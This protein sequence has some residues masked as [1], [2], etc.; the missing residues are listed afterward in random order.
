MARVR[1]PGK[2]SKM[3]STWTGPWRVTNASTPHVYQRSRYIVAGKVTIDAHVARL[4]FY[5]DSVLG[6]TEDV[7]AVFQYLFNQ[8]EFHME[9]VL[10]VRR[11]P[12]GEYEALVHWKGFSESERSWEPLTTLYEDAP[13]IS[14]LNLTSLKLPL[15][16]RKAILRRHD[17]RI[18]SG[19]GAR[20]PPLLTVTCSTGFIFF[21]FSE[22][23]CCQSNGT[24]AHHFTLLGILSITVSHPSYRVSLCWIFSG[25]QKLY[26]MPS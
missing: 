7:Q 22:L 18:N 19:T 4:K 3:T 24:W 23:L 2:T 13:R 6:I 1:Q 25:V 26:K 5:K 21:V 10:D 12:H 9:D 8:G 16:T 20:L 11:T 14:W 15:T 17:I